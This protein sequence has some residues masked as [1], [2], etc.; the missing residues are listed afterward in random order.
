MSRARWSHPA[1][2]AAAHAPAR[3]HHR[4]LGPARIRQRRRRRGPG[5]TPSRRPPP[6]RCASCP[7]S[8]PASRP[9][10]GYETAGADF[11]AAAIA[12]H[13]ARPGTH[14]LAEVM[15]MAA[16]TGRTPRMRGILQA[17]LASGKPVCGHARS[18][19]GPA[20]Q[21]YVASGH[22]LGPRADIDRRPDRPSPRRPVDRAARIPRPPVARLRRLLGIPPA[23]AADGDAVHR[24]RVSRRPKRAGGARRRAAPDDPLWPVPAQ[25]APS[26]DT[27]RGAADRTARPRPG[28]AGPPR[29]RGGARRPGRR[30]RAARAA[31]RDRARGRGAAGSP[32][33]G[34][35]DR[36]DALSRPPRR[37]RSC[38]ARRRRASGSSRSSVRAL[39]AGAR[40]G[41]RSWMGGCSRPR[42]RR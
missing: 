8:R 9:R 5:P 3:R 37:R 21:A 31:R 4:H 23:D 36:H 34:R 7:W 22:H 13:L 28:R 26:R 19:E 30:P 10:P 20:L 35:P 11:D 14:G 27:Q 16:V 25:G 15:D 29:R 18:L 32:R 33:A 2:Y 1:T 39:P 38:R 17:A 6:R 24:R 42:A 41:P 40:R 12:R